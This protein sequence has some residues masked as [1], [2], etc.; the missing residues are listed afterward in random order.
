MSFMPP[1]DF[2]LDMDAFE[3]ESESPVDDVVIVLESDARS[4]PFKDEVSENEK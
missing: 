2:D 4:P 3:F 1:S